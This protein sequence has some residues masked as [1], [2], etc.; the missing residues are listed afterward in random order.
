MVDTVN[1]LNLVEFIQDLRTQG[2]ELWVESGKLRY[3][4]KKEALTPQVFSQI[5]QS[6]LEIISLLAENKKESTEPYPL[7]IGQQALWFLYQLAPESIAYN[8]TYAVSLKP[9][10][11]REILEQAYT[12][13]IARHPSLRNTYK[14]IDGQPVQQIAPDGQVHFEVT[15]TGDL[16]QEYLDRWLAANA[17]QPFN[18]E[19][20]DIIR[21]YLLNRYSTTDSSE[22]PESVLLIVAHHI[23]MDFWSL[24]ILMDDLCL[25]YQSLKSGNSR[26]LPPIDINYQDYVYQEQAKL[27][28][29]AM[30]EQWQYWQKQLA[31]ELP[32]LNLSTDKTRPA[33]QTY[34]GVSFYFT[35][36]AELSQKI[37]DLAKNTNSTAYA[38]V[39]AAFQ[40]LLFR[41]TSQSELL[42]GCPMAG[43]INPELEKIIGYFVNP[44]VLRANLAGDPSF[45]SLIPQ[46]RQTL[47]EALDYQEMPFPLLVEKLQPDRDP[48]RSPLFQAALVWDRSRQSENKS[49]ETAREEIIVDYIAAEQRGA[50]FDL[51]LTLFDSGSNLQGNWRYNTDLFDA[52][53]IERMAGH[54]QTLLESIV[55][56]PE[57]PISQLSLLTKAEEQQLIVDWNNT[58]AEYL[59][60]KCIHQLF[61]SQVAKTPDAIAVVFEKQQLTYDEL[62]TRAN[63]LAHY[64]QTQGVK[65]ETLVAICVERSHLM[66]IGLLAILK[67]GG[68][69]VPLDPNYPQ[70]RLTEIL[71]DSRAPIILTQEDL[72]A[73]LP[74]TNVQIICL[75]SNL[76]TI[77]QESLGNPV[78]ELESD[79]LAYIIYTSGS[80]GKPKGVQIEHRSAVNL[81]HSIRRKPGLTEADTV[82]A[83]TTISFDVAVSEIFLPLA[84]GAK[85]VV[86]SSATAANGQ[87]LLQVLNTSKATFMHP[88]PITWRLLLAAGWQGSKNLKMVSTG[89]ALTQDLASQLLP[90]GKELWNLYGPTEITIW[91]TGYKVKSADHPIL[92][93]RP[94]DNMQTYVLD[95]NQQQVPIGVPG[96]L[97]IGGAGLARGYLHRPELTAEKF[98]CHETLNTRLYK[99][100]DLVRYLPDGN[101]ECLGR[102]D[103]QVKVRGF[104]I[105]LG[106]IESTLNTHPEIQQALVIAPEDISGNKRLVA[107]IASSSESIA[108]GTLRQFLKQKLPDYMVPSSFVILD[109]LPL[110][111]NGKVDRRSLPAPEQFKSEFVGSFVAPQDELELQLTKIWEKVLGI[112]Q[113][114]IEDN[115][116]ELGGHSFLAILLFAEIE[117]TIG[118]Q[119]PLAALFQAPNI[120]ALANLLRDEGWAS[121]WTSLVPIKP[122]GS[123]PPF[124]CMHGAG[125]HVLNY[126]SLSRY[127]SPEQPF[128]A[129]QAQGLD[130]KKAPHDNFAD[131]AAHYIQEIRELQPEGPYFLGGYCGGGKIALEMA[132]QLRASG[133]KVGLLAFFNTFNLPKSPQPESSFEQFSGKV[134]FL[135]QDIGYH[136]GNLSLLKPKDKL[137]FLRE[138]G[139][140][141]Q[142]RLQ[143]RISA[144]SEMGSIASLHELHDRLVME[145]EPKVYPG[146][147][148]IFQTRK[149]NDADYDS[150][151][152][153]EGLAEAGIEFHEIPAYFRG[154]LVEPF[155]KNLAEQLEICLERE[156]NKSK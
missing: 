4:G 55:A 12:Q 111:P 125:G 133:Q 34:N 40:V 116:F 108:T 85:L 87:E 24:D 145:Y 16:S 81:L 75:D 143:T 26:S 99:T 84:V 156:E 50:E 15:E 41:Y 69:Y 142:R 59:E 130:G 151:V 120:R 38:T 136:W 122:G 121:S 113:I 6:K 53:T 54:F 36:E 7:S 91:A 61:E 127:L 72:T 44:V 137:T 13:T 106:E 21:A 9:N 100:G 62:N 48:S 51:L 23:S 88:T 105:E 39:L 124:F 135:F 11:D 20:G 140:W 22:K 138:R 78:S 18:L 3:R 49:A 98:I 93:G 66:V 79:N 86:V 123:K 97:H 19:Q 56:H 101:I 63:Q 17:D 149:L 139:R 30:D 37:R 29:P 74:Q 45:E 114:G 10:I 131:M 96:E 5:K 58:E 109:K 1:N 134:K 43:R 144:K 25:L 28:S 119:L 146:K 35:L 68:A 102:I 103:N 92:I 57:R 129:L 14:T 147:I 46:V 67:A 152:G 150:Q 110:T 2:V 60:N 132:Q 76:K 31:G 128:Y 33:I 83:V 95:G 64:L 155:V 90:K 42:I 73:K 65:P 112:K 52:T 82:L 80:T 126:Y 115:F 77:E 107:Y 70:E 71:S 153:W 118:K 32:V 104:R 154:I 117:K 27:T 47:L 141:A 94:L 8:M 89:E 148:T